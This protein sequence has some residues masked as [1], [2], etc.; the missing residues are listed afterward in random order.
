MTTIENMLFDLYKPTT[1]KRLYFKLYYQ[2]NKEKILNY[3]LKR[4]SD[5]LLKGETKFINKK[6]TINFN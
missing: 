1:S 6:F 4:Y 3:N 2:K 5:R